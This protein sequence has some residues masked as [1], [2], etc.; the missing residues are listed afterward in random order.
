M[1]GGG[2]DSPGLASTYPP[3]VWNCVN[4][5]GWPNFQFTTKFPTKVDTWP[6][7]K[8][9]LASFGL[10]ARG[11]APPHY[12]G[13]HGVQPQTTA[14]A[15]PYNRLEVENMSQWHAL[16][17]KKVTSSALVIPHLKYYGQF[18]APHFKKGVDKILRDAV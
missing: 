10:L 6:D 15:Q 12:W 11:C 14:F 1:S 4:R 3:R 18:L 13:P 9:P 17:A 5:K 2:G 8:A 7:S 16:V